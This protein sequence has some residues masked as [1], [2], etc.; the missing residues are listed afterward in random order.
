MGMEPHWAIHER[1]SKRALW[2]FPISPSEA[3]TQDPSTSSSSCSIFPPLIEFPVRPV[4]ATWPHSMA[5]SELRI[6]SFIHLILSKR[7]R[8]SISFFPLSELLLIDEPE[9]QSGCQSASDQ[10]EWTVLVHPVIIDEPLEDDGKQEYGKA[11][12]D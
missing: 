1:S 9:D 5:C 2:T 8:F 10:T 12:D 3:R 6:L 4:S 11:R 7:R